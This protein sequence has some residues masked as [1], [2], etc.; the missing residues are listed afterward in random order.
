[1]FEKLAKRWGR[2]GTA[3]QQTPGRREPTQEQLRDQLSA[4]RSQAH[5]EYWRHREDRRTIASAVRAASAY[6]PLLALPHDSELRKTAAAHQG[7]LYHEAYALAVEAKASDLATRYLA[8]CRRALE[9]GV[10]SPDTTARGWAMYILCWTY[11]Q[12]GEPGAAD[13]LL[14]QVESAAESWDVPPE[15]LRLLRSKTKGAVTTPAPTPAEAGSGAA[16]RRL[17]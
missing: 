16:E 10:A 4:A 1:M 7:V 8:R 17:A 5:L 2:P 6:A 12:S 14:E 13:E 15:R 9:E 11:L 3:S